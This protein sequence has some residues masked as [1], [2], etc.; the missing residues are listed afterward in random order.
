VN[1]PN[2]KNGQKFAKAYDEDPATG[3]PK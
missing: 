3:E 2:I 1:D